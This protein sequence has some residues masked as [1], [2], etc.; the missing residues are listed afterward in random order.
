M[1][2]GSNDWRFLPHIPTTTSELTLL[3]A[4]IPAFMAKEADEHYELIAVPQ[5]LENVSAALWSKTY[6]SLRSGGTL[7]V[8]FS[9]RGSYLW[10]KRPFGPSSTPRQISRQLQQAGYQNLTIYGAFP[11]HLYPTYLSPLQPSMIRFVLP[12]YLKKI[13]SSFLRDQLTQGISRWGHALLP[14][15]A[16]IAVKA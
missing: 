14:A 2:K 3:A 10:K 8:G 11:N 6:R 15:Y 4:D 13:P 1:L 5:G 12:H 9:G 16:I 7:Y